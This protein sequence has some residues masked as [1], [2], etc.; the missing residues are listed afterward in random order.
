[1]APTPVFLPGKVHGWKSPA[2]YSPW[3]HKESD[4]T[5]RLSTSL[6]PENGKWMDRL[7]LL[8]IYL[9]LFKADLIIWPCFTGRT[10]IIIH[11]LHMIKLR[12]QKIVTYLLSRCLSAYKQACFSDANRSTRSIRPQFP[13]TVTNDHTQVLRKH[14]LGCWERDR[15]PQKVSIPQWSEI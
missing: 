5:E 2:G 6:L 9:N 3:S 10:W 13:S 12:L 1:M 8:L 11:T 15:N 4:T 7:W 14:S